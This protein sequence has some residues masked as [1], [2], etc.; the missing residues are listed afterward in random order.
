MGGGARGGAGACRIGID[1][2]KFLTIASGDCSYFFRTQPKGR[3]GFKGI[4][5]RPYKV[6]FS[7]VTG[8][9]D[10]FAEPSSI[11]GASLFYRAAIHV[12]LAKV[13]TLP[14]CVSESGYKLGLSSPLAKCCNPLSLC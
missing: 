11:A 3:T 9:V 8:S 14:P 2:P 1:F 13:F 4:L 5:L 12:S 6:H 7:L 10:L